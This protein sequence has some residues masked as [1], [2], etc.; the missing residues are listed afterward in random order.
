VAYTDILAYSK[1]TRD[2]DVFQ[3]AYSDRT[4]IYLV[5]TPGFDDTD[6]S[7]AEI[8]STLA[9]WL[10]FTYSNGIKLHGILY[11]HRITDLRMQGSARK[12]LRMF[13]KL[14]G[15]DALQKVVLVTTM[16]EQLQ[17][18][19][20]GEMREEELKTTEDYWGWMSQRGSRIE[21]HTNDRASAR[22]LVEIFVPCGERTA[23]E[24]ISLAIQEE[25]AEQN[26]P[27]EHTTAGEKVRDDIAKAALRISEAI[28]D[29][30]QDIR[31]AIQARDTQRR[32]D[33]QEI[34]TEMENDHERLI[35]RQEVLTR[36]MHEMI[37]AKYDQ[38][39]AE[40]EEEKAQRLS[41]EYV[42]RSSS[43]LNVGRS[44]RLDPIQKYPAFRASQPL[45][46]SLRG[47]HCSFIGPAYTKS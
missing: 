22:R 9:N 31:A 29:Y 4:N 26:K 46:L 38:A 14:C 36:D 13:N 5:D 25:M 7:D 10:V 18:Q 12:N 39:V 1:G 6:L 8:L 16:W 27:L 32:R 35:R 41:R 23:P 28:E 33:L 43:T 11:L 30:Q 17:S 2:C 47:R 21:R 40:R 3:C 24:Q 19:R 45:S 44:P 20:D 34:M 37:K 15:K 42:R